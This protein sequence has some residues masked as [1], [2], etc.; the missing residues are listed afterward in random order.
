MIEIR[1]KDNG[2]NGKFTAYVGDIKA[3]LISYMATGVS[4][5]SLMHTEVED[6]FRGQNIGKQIL[7]EIVEYAREN[8]IR[9]IPVCPFTITMFQR[10][11]EIGDVL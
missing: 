6:D 1:Q 11:P 3:G 5:I 8:N 2:I 9:I 10:L 7:L 4:E